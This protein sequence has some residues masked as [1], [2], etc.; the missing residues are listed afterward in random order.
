MADQHDLAPAL[1]MD[2]RLAM[3]FRHQRAGGIDGKKVASSGFCRDRFRHAVRGE[4]HRRSALGNLV[5]LLHEHRA[6]ALETF[7]HIAVMHDLVAYIDR[8]AID[9]Q[10]PLDGVDRPNHARTE[11]PWRAKHDFQGWF[12]WHGAISDRIAPDGPEQA[13]HIGKIR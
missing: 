2:L 8:L 3:D 5:E 7:N 4:D 1:V 10:R 6:L 12:G 9:G 11:A 13:I